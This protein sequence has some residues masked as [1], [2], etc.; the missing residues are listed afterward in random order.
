MGLPVLIERE[1][2]DR[3][4]ARTGEPLPLTAEGATADEA[5]ERL[6]ALM[7]ERLSNGTVLTE[8]GG[9]K[10]TAKAGGTP[11]PWVA[12]T[13]DL[14][15]EPLFDEWVAAMAEYRREVDEREAWR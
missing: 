2:D 5:L 15:N 8:V 4:R 11:N 7:D 9:S 3:Y 14:E 12:I 10:G 1:A 6:R 13:G